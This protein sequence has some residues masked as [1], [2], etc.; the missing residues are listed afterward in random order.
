MVC[1]NGEHKHT[2]H[3]LI[4][5]INMVFIVYQVW[6]EL[7]QLKK[8]G[9]KYFN[10]NESFKDISAYNFTNFADITG[11]IINVMLVVLTIG[12][13]EWIDMDNKRIM[14][15]FLVFLTW[16]KMFNWLRLFDSTTFYIKLIRDTL[17]AIVPFFV[18]FLIFLATFGCSMYI[19]STNRKENEAQV[20]P[21]FLGNWVEDIMIN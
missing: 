17:K 2:F 14:A 11:Y 18:I 19:L 8:D 10:N 5:I 15:S 12:E 6:V 13:Y 9:W 1:G 20:V 21:T 16:T 4:G 7:V 3:T